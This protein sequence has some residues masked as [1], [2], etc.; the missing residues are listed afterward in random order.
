MDVTNNSKAPQGIHTLEGVVYIQPGQTKSV[1]LNKTLESHAKGLDFFDLEGDAE[2]DE[3]GMPDSA[4]GVTV[5]TAQLDELKA[6]FEE[7]DTEIG[8]L[9][10]ENADL[11]SKVGER[12][13]TITKLEGQI[14][15]LQQR[16]QAATAAQKPSDIAVGYTVNE[17]SPGWF[18]AFDADGK[19][20]GSK[21]R[22]ADA[23]TFK[24]M[25]PE[26]QKAYLSE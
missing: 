14:V 8:H 24:G 12:D 23:E 1:R 3:L 22:E 10:S 6:K 13:E 21:M 4:G 19:Q 20:V 26:E 25:T 18:A 15:E 7:K 9:T 17:T 11:N 2:D 16:L 5:S